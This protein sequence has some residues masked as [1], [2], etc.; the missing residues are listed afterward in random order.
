MVHGAY[1]VVKEHTLLTY[2]NSPSAAFDLLKSNSAAVHNV[3]ALRML[4]I[5]IRIRGVGIV[6]T[7]HTV[8]HQM[9]L[10]SLC[11]AVPLCR[12]TGRTGVGTA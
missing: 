6:F 3:S 8:K 11:H 10:A 12:L 4:A 5:H 1:D 9:V 2:R 7:A